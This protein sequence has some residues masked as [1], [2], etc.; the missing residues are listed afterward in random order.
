MNEST[1]ESVSS[2]AA[3]IESFENLDPPVA[4][5]LNLLEPNIGQL[6]EQGLPENPRTIRDERF[7][8][9]K[10]NIRKYPEFLRRNSLIVYPYGDDKYVI[11]GGN[12]RYDA[13]KELGYKKAPCQILPKETPIEKLKAYIVLDNSDFGQWDWVK[14][15]SEDWDTDQLQGWGVECD[16]LSDDFFVEDEPDSGET[17]DDYKEPEKDYLECPHCHHVDS[18]VHFKKVANRSGANET[19]VSESLEELHDENLPIGD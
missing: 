19:A 3:N 1:K 15:Q 6:K 16:F 14:L 7:D 8:R 4:L 12:Q 10:E 18:K 2:E 5:N 11:I 17:L 9:L 13:L